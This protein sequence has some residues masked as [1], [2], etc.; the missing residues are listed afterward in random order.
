MKA[1]DFIKKNPFCC[2]CGGAE[3]AT[4]IEHL[5]ARI[6]F[7]KKHR[8]KGLEFPACAACNAQTRSDDSVLAIVAQALGSMRTNVPLIDE[9][10]LARAARGTQI[11]FPGFKL[12]GREEL[13]NVN[14]VIR[15]VGI[16]D[17]NHPTVHL[18]LCRLAAKFALAAFYELTGTIADET[19][20]VNTMWTHNQHGEAD[21]IANILRMFPHSTS[22]KQG[23]WDT[24][25]TFYFRH[26]REDDTLITAGVFFEAMLLYAH[27][28]PLRISASWMPM[29]MTWAPTP[30]IGVVQKALNA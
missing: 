13:R 12:A 5:P 10:T 6:V 2:F 4:T 28:G 23:A 22:L 11:S 9:D 15:K 29:Q 20:R 14:G 26:A 24:A 30:R 21:E 16:V 17:A 1:K 3:P 27:L 7:P 8:P 25:E 18:C 19:Y